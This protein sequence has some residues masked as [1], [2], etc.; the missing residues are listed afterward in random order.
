MY[1]KIALDKSC[2]SKTDQ[3]IPQN[4]KTAASIQITAE[5]HW[6][7][8]LTEC[9]S[10]GMAGN[11]YKWRVSGSGN[12]TVNTTVTIKDKVKPTVTGVTFPTGMTFPMGAQVP[13]TVTFSEPVQSSGVKLTANGKELTAREANTTAKRLTFLYPVAAIGETRIE[14]TKVSG[15]RDVVGNTMNDVS[16]TWL[17][18]SILS[19][20]T[21]EEAF[22]R[23]S[24]QTPVVSDVTYYPPTANQAEKTTATVRVDIKLP[25]DASLRNLSTPAYMDGDTY[26]SSVLAASIDGGETLIPLMLDNG[27]NPTKLTATVELDAAKLITQQNYVMEFYTI[28]G[29]THENTGLLFG[30]YAAFSVN[31]PVPL[32][33]EHLSI[34]TPADWPTEPIFLNNPPEAA[35]LT[36]QAVVKAPAGTTWTQTWW[37]SSDESV[38]TINANGRVYPLGAGTVEFYLEAVNGNLTEYTGE[39]S[40]G[41]AL[42]FQQGAE[43]Y[44]RIP[45]SK[46]TIRS[47]DPVTVRWASNLVQKNSEYGGGAT[48]FTITVA[49]PDGQ[50]V[51]EPY[52]VTY[53][54]ADQSDPVLWANGSPNQSFSINSLT[55]TDTRGYTVTVSASAGDAVPGAQEDFTAQAKVTVVSQPVSVRLTRPVNLFQ[56]NQGVLPVNYMLENYGSKNNT[57]FE[58]VVTNNATGDKVTTISTPGSDTGGSFTIYDVSLQAKNTAEPDW[59]R[60]SFTLYIYDKNCLDILV[61]PVTKGGVTIVDVDG[62]Q[63][64]MSNEAWIASLTQDQILALNRDIDLQAAISI[65]YSDHAWGE[66]SDRIQWVSENSTIAAVNY[67]QGA[68]Y[69]NIESLPYTSFAPATQFLISGKN[70]GKTVA[71]AIHALAGDALSSSVEITMETLKDKLYLFQFYPVGKA[72]LTYTNGD[73]EP[74]THETEADGRAAIYEPSG[75]SADV[76]V[77]ADIGGEKY[78]GTVYQEDLVSQEKDAVSLELYPL[79]SLN[80]RKAATLPVYLKKPDGTNYDGAVTVRAGVYRNGV[81]C[82][83]TMYNTAHRRRHGQ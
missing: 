76:Y 55:D 82:E 69:E 57:Q 60:D 50:Q 42:T 51:G 9:D 48:T 24:V 26:N 53:D 27:T 22:S 41:V 81:Y 16:G 12:F 65:N 75:I 14:V 59:S 74:R 32:M 71:E 13:V 44:L 77:E 83:D 8:V 62:D 25:T 2:L 39:R 54:P 43:P 63:V 7:E 3:S 56:I 70:N 68:Y 61:Q 33:A 67:P 23:N 5:G 40:K 47:G 10:T 38:A 66:A 19:T 6:D 72:T 31:K 78:L 73:G 30:R 1:V 18:D 79:N 28:D 52:T 36:L 37:V 34:Q 21:L 49:G 80:L 17:S 4:L 35:A 64:T 46:M 15:A 58:L 11:E 20:L 45:E 29:T